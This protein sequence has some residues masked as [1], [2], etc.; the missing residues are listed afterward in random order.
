MLGAKIS[1]SGKIAL[2]RTNEACNATIYK[3]IGQKEV[4]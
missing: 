1:Q 4:F 3:L 2:C